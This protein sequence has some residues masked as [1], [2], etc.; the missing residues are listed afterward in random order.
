MTFFVCVL[1]NPLPTGRLGEM[2]DRHTDDKMQHKNSKI[3]TFCSTDMAIPQ[4]A[5]TP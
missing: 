3:S 1:D 5:E 4:G 2:K